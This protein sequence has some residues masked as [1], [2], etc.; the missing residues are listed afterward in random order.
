MS[1]TRWTPEERELIVRLLRCVNTTAQRED[2]EDTCICGD[3]E[4]LVAVERLL[5]GPS[6]ADAEESR[7]VQR[8]K[9]IQ[10]GEPVTSAD[11]ER[12]MR[13]EGA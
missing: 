8:R 12:R 11:A 9:A 7:S 2:G 1:E 3:P 10:R 5:L 13:E 4:A 6:P